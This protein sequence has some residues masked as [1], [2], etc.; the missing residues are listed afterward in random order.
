LI[1]QMQKAKI[2][3]D[4][5]GRPKHL[6][7]IYKKMAAKNLVYEQVYDV[8]AFRILV[9]SLA[10]CYEALG[11]VHSLYKPVPGRFKDF[12]AMAKPNNYQSL[13][14]TIIGPDAERI[15]IQIRTYGMHLVAERGIAAHWKY[16][17]GY[18]ADDSTEKAFSWLRDL[19]SSHQQVNDATEF[20]ETLKGDLFDAETYV[21]TPKGEVKVLPDG[22]TPIDFAYSIHTDVGHRVVGAKVDGRMVPLRY[23]LRNGETIEI[24]TGPKQSPSKDWLNFCVTSRAQSKIRAFIRSNE[25]DRAEILGKD[26][27]DKELRRFHFAPNKFYKE[28]DFSKFFKNQGIRTIEDMFVHIG[29]GKLLPGKALE[30]IVPNLRQDSSEPKDEK[31][32]FLGKVIKSAIQRSEKSRSAI[33]VDG[34]ND[35]LVRYAKCC[36]PI[37]GDPIVGFISRGRGVTIHRTNCPKA[38]EL[39]TERRIDVKWS[40]RSDNI[41]T[42]RLRVVS[43]DTPGLLQSMSEC[44]TQN[45]ININNAQ[46]RT[47]KDHK[48]ISLF[49]VSVKDISQMTKVIADLQKI[50][51][52][53]SV[54]R[55]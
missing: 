54:D 29:Y 40:T 38:F 10:Q 8:L 1:Q 4:I 22:A 34:M 49:D 20:L 17:E 44:F 30:L 36:S 11:I 15:E 33:L 2:K 12:I 3:C 32:T 55:I 9:E 21:F 14:T 19:V 18:K 24:I 7:S 23:K 31:T 5:Q 27:F 35:M 37:P 41:R 28:T 25:R 16:K 48:A 53:L 46:I 26:L 43:L 51:G 45:G 39:D 50:R 13:H 42:S 6:Y 52:V 47:N